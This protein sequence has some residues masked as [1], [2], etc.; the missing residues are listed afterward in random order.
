MDEYFCPNCGAILNNQQGFD[1]TEG[2]WTCT[3]CGEMLTGD[4]VY[5]GENFPGVAW[6]CD[7]CGAFLNLQSGFTDSCESWTCTACGHQNGITEEDIIDDS[8]RCPNCGSKLMNQDYYADWKNDWECTK[9]GVNLHRDYCIDPFEIVDEDDEN[10]YEYDEDYE[11]YED[12]ANDEDEI[13]G[14][15]SYIAEEIAKELLRESY[16]KENREIKK[17]VNPKEVF[18]GFLKFILTLAVIG[19]CVSVVLLVQYCTKLI[20]TGV[21]S[22]V[23]LNRE[24]DSVVSI[25]E[26]SGFTNIHTIPLEDLD[27]I[28]KDAVGL[29]E[30]VYIRGKASFTENNKYPYDSN[31]EVK[32]HSIGQ[33][34]IPFSGK[35]AKGEQ[36]Q[37]IVKQLSSIGFGDFEITADYDLITGLFN[38][39]GEIESISIDGE[40]KFEK[41]QIFPADSKIEIIYHDFKKNKPDE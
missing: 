24:Y 17:S 38:K 18:E 12:D 30:R 7:E 32:Y 41:G 11:E 27:Y 22:D 35:E 14:R 21:S 20:P 9:C 13:P 40:S 31:I 1:P 29:V 19:V 23:L 33:K 34:G 16:R 39:S 10:E 26:D 36:Y 28:D 5:D 8:P 25:L 15:Y 2:Y 4:D 6:F 37:E 3:S